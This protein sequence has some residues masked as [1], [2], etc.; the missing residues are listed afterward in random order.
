MAYL[1]IGPSS[2][3]AD[4]LFAAPRRHLVDFA[5]DEAVARVFPDMIR[6]SVPGYAEVIALSGL[7]AH[8][9]SPTTARIYDLGCS[10]G[11]TSLAILNGMES[12]TCQLIGVD[13][14][15]AMIEQCRQELSRHPRYRQLSLLCGDIRQ[16]EL[17]PASVVVMN[18]TLQFIPPAE[19]VALL[20][21][22]YHALLPGGVLLL[23]EKITAASDGASDLLQQL[24]LDFKRANGYS[25][26][27]ISQKRTAL[28][29][30]LLPESL[31]LHR[32]RLAEV[33]FSQTILWHQSLNFAALLAIKGKEG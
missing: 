18:Y 2:G 1:P 13:N 3:E 16:L 20:T 11:A 24:H 26:L 21:R 23:A 7:I 9:F 22:I 6:R 27:E 31:E 32:Q 8:H 28:E 19:R 15:A 14:S 17:L 33:G 5:F 12:D 4:T 30:V 10:R 29:R 25:D